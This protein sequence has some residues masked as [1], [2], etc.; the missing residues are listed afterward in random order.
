MLLQCEA[1]KQPPHL[2][3]SL[4]FIHNPPP[5][6]RGPNSAC[7][8]CV[9]VLVLI[10]L[11][12]D[13][14]KLVEALT[15]RIFDLVFLLQRAVGASRPGFRF[16]IL[17]SDCNNYLSTC[18]TGYMFTDRPLSTLHVKIHHFSEEHV[19]LT[20]RVPELHDEVCSH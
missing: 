1:M 2:V 17:W 7:R 19:Y 14:L 11:C 18:V 13:L 8:I 6:H 12:E 3:I 10:C 4:H 15:V 16:R 20:G 5:Y 9:C